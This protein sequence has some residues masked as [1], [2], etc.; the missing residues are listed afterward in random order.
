[1][2]KNF[3]VPNLEEI[4]YVIGIDFGHGE[5]S[6]AITR[7]NSEKD[8]EDIDF[9]GTGKKAIPSVMHVGS[10]NKI[11][12]GDEAV[13]QYTREGG[14][15]YAYFKQS[16]NTLDEQEIPNLHVMKLFMKSVYE[17]ICYRRSGEL[18]EGSIIKQNHVVFIACPS[19]SQKWD[20]QAMQN[21]VQLALDA[22][23]PIAGVS[24]DDKFTLSGIVRESRAA[25]IRMLQKDEAAQKSKEGILVVDYGS[26]TIDITYY[27]E[28]ENP[29]D[30]GYSLGAS[31]VEESI[32]NYLQ[33]Y[34]EDLDGDQAPDFLKSLKEQNFPLYTGVL[35]KMRKQK[36]TFYTDFSFANSIEISYK[37]P[38]I[39][40]K[41]ELD[42]E[43][44]KETL[45]QKILKDYIADVKRAFA[46][47]KENVIKDKPITLLV[48]TG[49]A[50]RMNFVHD[51]AKSVFGNVKMLPPQDPSLTVSNGIAT[52]GRADIKL[53]Y[54][55]E[56]LFKNPT[57]SDLDITDLV[58]EKISKALATKVIGDMDL[59]Y[60]NFKNQNSTES[61]VS[62]GEKVSAKIKQ[63]NSSC[64]DVVQRVFNDEMKIKCN[65]TIYTKLKDYLK[66]H[67]PYL[68]IKQ[69]KHQPLEMKVNI[70]LQTLS[71]IDCA[72]E[73]SAKEAEDSVLI[74]AVKAIYNIGAL[75]V[76]A[77]AK[78]ELEIGN[79]VVDLGKR[80]WAFLNGDDPTAIKR[81]KMPTYDDIVK[82]LLIDFN[83]KNTLLDKDK[84][85]K[86]YDAFIA[87]KFSYEQSLKTSIKWK[88]EDDK[89]LLNELQKQTKNVV[90]QY[91]VDEIN[92]IQLQIK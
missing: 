32:F 21:Y 77:I 20:D 92:R 79:I 91:I 14:N 50:S 43:I 44:S 48:L 33:E 27:K 39:Y 16:P 13:H 46:D 70:S 1:M 28:D 3:I 24:I 57:I 53:Y 74:D 4:E 61:V 90:N 11:T 84:R 76:A 12:L 83:N 2:K 68:N 10:E 65:E 85:T 69:V 72:I 51:L 36:E 54:I 5:T 49:G 82:G 86:V 71:A 63:I 52:A 58:C 41:I 66:S 89:E 60:T 26:S 73:V 56:D 75:L 31:I 23:L 22:G 59:C 17:T 9:T 64:A 62:L 45:A 18:M 6:A 47:F 38:R 8:P 87:N 88:L 25:Y 19:K 7:I 15:F 37:F 29:V 55:A 67:F 81:T 80:A 40:G 35:Y 78:I 42:V 34:H 30:K